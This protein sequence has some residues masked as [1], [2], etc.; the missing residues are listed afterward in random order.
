L[1]K[2]RTS[3]ILVD[4]GNGV[5]NVADSRNLYKRRSVEPGHLPSSGFLERS[6]HALSAKAE[7]SF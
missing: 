2:S 6:S 5:A 1:E 7:T 4:M 3:H